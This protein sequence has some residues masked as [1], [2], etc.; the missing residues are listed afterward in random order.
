MRVR[1]FLN[2]NMAFC[3]KNIIFRRH[4]PGGG[5]R[6]ALVI[7]EA[8]SYWSLSDRFGATRGYVNET[9]ELVQFGQEG[10]RE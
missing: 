6:G 7:A 10:K 4:T 2:W 5:G 9:L 8:Q 3:N 1:G